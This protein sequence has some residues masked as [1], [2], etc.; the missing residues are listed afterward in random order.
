MPTCIIIH[1]QIR[2]DYFN[3]CTV[4]L[5]ICRSDIILHVSCVFPVAYRLILIVICAPVTM[6]LTS[7]FLTAHVHVRKIGLLK[8][9][10]SF[11][12]IYPIIFHNVIN[13]IILVILLFPLPF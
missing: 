7:T 4:L 13:F 2:Y 6:C 10:H 5:Y 8:G 12:T 3:L 11:N 9:V 1:M